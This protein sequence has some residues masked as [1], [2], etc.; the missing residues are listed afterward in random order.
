MTQPLRKTWK[1]GDL[2]DA[3]ALNELQAEA[4]GNTPIVGVNNTWV[5]AGIDTGKPVQGPQGIQ[6]DP[7]P[8][9]DK[10]EPGDPATVDLTG[11]AKESWVI[12]QI[13]NAQIPSDNTAP[14]MS[15]YATSEEFSDAL[16]DKA[17]AAPFGDAY[18]LKSEIPTAPEGDSFALKSDIPAPVDLSGYALVADVPTPPAGDSFALKSEI[19]TVEAYDDKAI[20]DR[21]A[22]AEAELTEMK[23][24]LGIG[25][26]A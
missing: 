9:G 7:G 13:N 22:K 11:Y 6:G 26:A 25:G 21:L 23:A 5:V 8:K 20:L 1:S 19:P 2:L 14:D 12:T 17:D 24:I 15:I 16:A 10:G 18:A 3:K 4:E